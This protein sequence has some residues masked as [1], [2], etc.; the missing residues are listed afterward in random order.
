M[1]SHLQIISNFWILL[2]LCQTEPG[3]CTPNTYRNRTDP[4]GTV[5]FKK[6]FFLLLFWKKEENKNQSLF[7]RNQIEINR[8]NDERLLRSIRNGYNGENRYGGKYSP[9]SLP[10]DSL[11]S[12]QFQLPNLANVSE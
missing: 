7:I 2:C 1:F 11:E 10:S 9:P 5:L 12:I 4:I 6:K 3:C 8:Q